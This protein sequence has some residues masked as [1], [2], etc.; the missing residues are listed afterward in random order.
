[1]ILIH[2]LIDP[3]ICS[4]GF[5]EIRWYG[6]AY[7]AAFLIGGYLI[8]SFNK[9]LDSTL[10]NKLIDNF[11]IWSIIGVILGGRIGYVLFYQ[12]DNFLHNPLY[13]IYIWQGGMS[14]HG[15]LIG[16]ILSMM[17]F[18]KKNNIIFFQLSDLV[19][20]VAPIGLFLGRIANFINV[21]LIGKVTDFP[22]AI[23]F[24]SIDNLPRHPSQ[25][26]EAFF[27][28]IILFFILF[29]IFRNNYSIKKYGL[30]S[31]LFLF[32]YG[33]FRF[34]I[35]FLREPDAHIGLFFNLLS[36]GQLLSIPVIIF[37]LIILWKKQS[38]V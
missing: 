33:I 19:S 30:L 6:I 20:L 23:I 14:F 16:M 12:L 22:F 8:K 18:A 5:L 27:E 21:E 15:G 25:L 38:Y 31:G 32:F 24:P 4:F 11:F 13:I 2:P 10:S 34:F 9:K 7:V 29:F 28:G 1:M 35:E 17:L 37:G 36:L 26:Y 3:V